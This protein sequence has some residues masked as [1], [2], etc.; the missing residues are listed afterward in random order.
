MTGRRD[1]TTV[2]AQALYLLNSSFVRRQS[3]ALAERLL[4]QKDATDVDRIRA[5]YRLTLAR[6]PAEKEVARARTFLA[7]YES[8]YREHARTAQPE[9]RNV[10]KPEKPKPVNPQPANPD[11]IDQTGEAVVDEA[12]RPR[13]ARTAAWLGLVQA[14]Y[15]SAE[16]R[17]LK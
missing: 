7:E 17:Y 4:A 12:V 5:A 1:T 8:A 10:T 9:D 2:P 14:L 13:D 16:F 15:S 6:A 11:E 3:L